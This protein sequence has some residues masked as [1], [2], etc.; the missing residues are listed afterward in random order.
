MGCSS[1]VPW[2]MHACPRTPWAKGEGTFYLFAGLGAATPRITDPALSWPGIG[3]RV[4]VY[5]V[6][7]TGPPPPPPPSPGCPLQLS[8]HLRQ[9]RQGSTFTP[10]HEV[11]LCTPQSLHTC[12]R[13]PA[14]PLARLAAGATAAAHL[15]QCPR[16]AAQLNATWNALRAGAP[17]HHKVLPWAITQGK[18]GTLLSRVLTTCTTTT[19]PPPSASRCAL[20]QRQQPNASLHPLH[21]RR[22]HGSGDPPHYPIIPSGCLAIHHPPSFL[23][24]LHLF[25]SPFPPT[26]PPASKRSPTTAVASPRPQFLTFLYLAILPHPA[27]IPRDRNPGGNFARRR[28]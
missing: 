22:F 1:W 6:V 23:S 4:C 16:R 12:A 18:V 28:R 20:R 7:W 26:P 19:R 3:G 2:V 17:H 15:E 5:V 21:C 14:R 25:F 9:S 10:V 8:P 11:L 13:T 24:L 27:R